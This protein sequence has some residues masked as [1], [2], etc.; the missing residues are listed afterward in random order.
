[1]ATV[2]HALNGKALEA[3]KSVDAAGVGGGLVFERYFTDGK[4]S[5]FDK[6][7]WEK[8]TALIGTKRAPQSSSRK[9]L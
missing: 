2:K 4:I 5:P 7:E 1:M 6:V 9:T 3:A 8:R